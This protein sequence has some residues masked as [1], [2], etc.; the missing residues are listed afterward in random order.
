M[1]ADF[2]AGVV[3]GDSGKAVSGL[4]RAGELVSAAVSDGGI[5]G[6]VAAVGRGPVTLST[7]VSGQGDT[8]PAT[9]R[10]MTAVTLFD[11]ASLT[12]L[13]A[14]TTAVL[15]L[16]GRGQLDLDDPS[17]RYLPEFTALRDGHVTIRHL[18][19]HTS[20]LPDTRKFY[21]WCS[22]RKE[23]LRALFSTPLEAPPGT[24]VT[25]SD[26]GFIALG[27]IVAAI[28]GRPLD[29]A[30]G[31][32]VTG[33]LGMTSTGYN[34]AAAPDRFAATER[35]EDGTPV[36]GVVH[37]ENAR[38]MG[39]VAGH[40]GLFS[41]VS[42]LAAFCAWWVSDADTAVP[43]AL[44]REAESA[45]TDG[46]GGN[47]GLGW[48]RGGDRYDILGGHWPAS[49]VS[50]TGF[51]GTSLALDSPSGVWAVLLTNAVHFGR[52]AT[53]SKALRREFS[54]AVATAFFR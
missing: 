50:H 44:R 24:R 39:G 51:T 46:L 16:A 52:D 15:A 25:Y 29:A 54:A 5:P 3:P 40:A 8:T 34:P 18:L 47:R 19:T 31:D 11:L 27:E 37:D 48:V 14:T 10:P 9:A 2:P 30:V 13:V 4:T 6:A 17:A 12:K 20:G 38:L 21:Q 32:L 7:W 36:N 35:Q 43:A 22:S 42:D 49:A 33:P 26:L 53:A 23:L 28:A 41:V 1:S 45:Q